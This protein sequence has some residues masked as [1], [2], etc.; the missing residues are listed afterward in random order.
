MWQVIINDFD[1]CYM[2]N[3][4][5]YCPLIW[6]ILSGMFCTSVPEVVHYREV[7]LSLGLFY[8]MTILFRFHIDL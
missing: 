1:I 6:T 5:A 3:V 8:S 4:C 7:L 2:L